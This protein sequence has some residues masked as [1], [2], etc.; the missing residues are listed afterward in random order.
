MFTD[1]LNIKH[2]HQ[3]SRVSRHRQWP[4][5]RES[6]GNHREARESPRTG[7]PG[8]FRQMRRD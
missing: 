5:A 6:R 8:Q 3:T 4:N 7:P 2:G 1:E